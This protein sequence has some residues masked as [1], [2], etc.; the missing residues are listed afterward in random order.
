M[1]LQSTDIISHASNVRSDETAAP[2]AEA[3]SSHLVATSEDA[4]NVREARDA[5]QAFSFFSSAI[6]A[7]MGELYEKLAHVEV[8]TSSDE[9]YW[10]LAGVEA[11]R[12]AA[13]SEA[14]W[15]REQTEQM[16]RD[17]EHMRE[18]LERQRISFADHHSAKQEIARLR[19]EVDQLRQHPVTPATAPEQSRRWRLN[20]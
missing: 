18:E 4:R 8:A 3:R 20:R 10:R 7:Q 16:E 1:V 19:A 6:A 2:E 12:E 5:M 9:F 14:R 15:L 13:R 17:V 11:E